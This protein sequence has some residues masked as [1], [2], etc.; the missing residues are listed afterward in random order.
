[1]SSSQPRL[2]H[3]WT[4]Y[5]GNPTATAS[6]GCPPPQAPPLWT[7]TELWGTRSSALGA[8]AAATGR[9]PPHRPEIVPCPAAESASPAADSRSPTA[10]NFLPAP[11]NSESTSCNAAFANNFIQSDFKTMYNLPSFQLH[12]QK[13]S[14]T[15]P[16][17]SPGFSSKVDSKENSL[18]P[19]DLFP[20]SI[21]SKSFTSSTN[22]KSFT[23]ST[24][25]YSEK[26]SLDNSVAVPR[27]R[28]ESFDASPPQSLKSP[29]SLNISTPATPSFGSL[30]PTAAF[31][32]S[33][34][35]PHPEDSGLEPKFLF[36]GCLS[37]VEH[38]PLMNTYPSSV[39][40]KSFSSLKKSGNN[41]VASSNAGVTPKFSLTQQSFPCQNGL[42]SEIVR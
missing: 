15:K 32:D 24:F 40:A 36:P 27:A 18:K 34:L 2:C 10:N 29:N 39:A 41:A 5:S 31:L 30:S 28:W 19:L 25:L 13:Y 35:T 26:T 12:G 21:N 8:P 16:A 3:P 42:S 11:R 14:A 22:S 7:G 37:G 23:S 1:M 38:P 33:C 9:P 6:G 20:Q 4:K 17:T